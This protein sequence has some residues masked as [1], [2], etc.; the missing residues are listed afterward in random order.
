MGDGARAHY[1]AAYRGV[2][3]SQPELAEM[4]DGGWKMEEREERKMRVRHQL[5]IKTDE[6]HH[7][8]RRP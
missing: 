5:R 6:I 7:R 1:D 4:G 8:S 2:R 3:I